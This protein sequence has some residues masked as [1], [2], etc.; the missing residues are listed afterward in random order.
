MADLARS[1][2]VCYRRNDT[3][4][5]A[6]RLRDRLI[7]E[8]GPRS[9]FMDVDTIRPGADFTAAID[10]ALGSCR[11]VLVLIGQVWLAGTDPSGRRRIT[12]PA[13]HVVV[14]IAT[15]LRHSLPI[16]PVLADGAQMP[17]RADLPPLLAELTTRNAVRVDHETFGRD[18]A[19]VVE[20]VAET[21]RPHRRA[22]ARRR[23]VLPLLAV[24]LVLLV[25]LGVFVVLPALRNDEVV[26]RVLTGHIAGVSAVTT[27]VRD[28][29]PVA[30]TGDGDGTIR[31]WD[32]LSGELVGTPLTG[33]TGFFY[34]LSTTELDGRTVIVS[35]G[36]DATIRVWDLVTGAPVGPTRAGSDAINVVST[37]VVDGR[38]VVVTTTNADRAVVVDL[39]TDRPLGPPLAGHEGGILDSATGVLDGRPVVVTVDRNSKIGAWD[40]GT[41]AAVGGAAS[42]TGS[43]VAEPADIL[44]SIAVA[45]LHRQPV[46]VVNDGAVLRAS[47]LATG[48]A[49]GGPVDSRGDGESGVV[50]GRFDGRPIVAVGGTDGTIQVWDL[51][52]NG[53]TPH[54]APIAGTGQAGVLALAE[55]G[56]DPILVAGEADGSVHVWNLHT[57]LGS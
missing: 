38:P 40:L 42:C 24:G 27:A 51:E 3:R 57:V 41:G 56:T 39:A 47:Y 43:G 2:F 22:A 35:S 21:L 30:I 33:H 54:G 12:D 49:L 48:E 44:C 46:V 28:G 14:E 9:V 10:E 1:I 7:E 16:V 8:F 4:H 26:E 53:F 29:R 45:D 37:D 11:I 17:A 5:L 23:L 20:T 34:S 18:S 31:I 19:V 50:A 32:L 55:V 15:A 13:D 25:A 52:V 36:D 6:G